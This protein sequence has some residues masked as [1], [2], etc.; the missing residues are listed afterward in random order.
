MIG[1]T[2]SHYRILEK[3]GGGGMGVVYKAEDLKLGRLVA[4]KFLPEEFSRDPHALERFQREARAASALNHPNICTIH[5]IDEADGRHF[6]AMELLEG[7]T[8]RQRIAGK[9]MSADE[10]L[11][12]GIQ[13][14]D[15]LDGAHK[16]GII[17]RDIKPANV[18]L[19]ERG[20]AKLLDFGLAKLTAGE[21]AR[22]AGVFEGT[23]YVGAEEQLTRP[24]AAVG[25]VAYMSPEQARG[26]QLDARTDLFSFG[27]V[28]YEMATGRQAFSASSVA[29]V[30]DAIL[31]SVPALPARLNPACPPELENIVTKTLEKD[32][33]LRY[34]TAREILADLSRLKRS[35]SSGQVAAAG[36]EQASIVV[37]P[38]ENLSPDP[39]NAFFADG[40]TE[41]LIAD[42]SNVHTLRIISR[43]SAMLL[44]GSKKDIPTIARELKVRYALEGSVRRAGNSLRITAQLIDAATDVHVWAEKYS[45]TLEDVFGFQERLSRAIVDALR[46]KLTPQE[47][48]RLA[49]RPI[50]S[51]TAYECYL[52]AR[53]EIWRMVPESYEQALRLAREGLAIVGENELLHWTIGHAYAMQSVWGLLSPD[54]AHPLIG[55]CVGK[56]LMLNPHSARGHALL[57][58]MQYRAGR[59]A[60]S[61]R[62]FR[63]SLELEPNDPDVLT[64]L[65]SI[66]LRAGI[67][68]PARPLVDRLVAID[69]LTPINYT[70][71]AWF[72][73]LDGNPPDEV[74]AVGRRYMEADPANHYACFVT[75][76]GL[77]VTGRLHEEA[78]P[79]LERLIREA[80]ESG[81]GRWAAVAK[82]AVAGNRDAA[83]NA[84][85]PE[86]LS[87]ARSDDVASLALSVCY[88][89]LGMQDEVLGWLA[90]AM[91]MGSTNYPWVTKIPYLI[92][93]L[94]G[95]RAEEFLARLRAVWETQVL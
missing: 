85:T 49:E 69:P 38:F 32:R 72:D 77:C 76:L 78:G 67:S 30:F 51:I 50:S 92:R 44:R 90:N 63:R 27:A 84:V 23:T 8:L 7:K 34:Q 75:L 80:P 48:V 35:R 60:D 22:A 42:L 25:T 19:T 37:L 17:H 15:A 57:G 18:F 5:D 61:A 62:A 6:I 12:L 64:W 31:H 41:E 53:Y 39:D 65:I 40:L 28:L 1:K 66:Y 4:L 43:T 68:A 55:E 46:V 88:A 47:A 70:W 58:M 29:M 24:G 79:I 9:P 36:P 95:A 59:R 20:V 33:A 16:K 3:L 14:A 87:W 54:V 81:F 82:A 13:I 11:D 91:A 73:V 52:K 26:E 74:V 94:R 89:L 86:L 83:L 10:V 21:A 93:V 56:I 71:S 45:G 2:I